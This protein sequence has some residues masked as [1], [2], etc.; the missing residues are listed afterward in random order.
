MKILLFLLVV[1]IG[2]FLGNRMA[3]YF[4]V[5][6]KKHLKKIAEK[7]NI[8]SSTLWPDDQAKQSAQFYVDMKRKI[9][10]MSN[11]EL[12]DEW[13]DIVMFCEYANKWYAKTHSGTKMYSLKKVAEEKL[14][15]AR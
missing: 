2:L 9:F 3:V 8:V 12:V 5:W 1:S 11:R 15:T 6:E 4:D 7:Q 13:D 14:S 10:S